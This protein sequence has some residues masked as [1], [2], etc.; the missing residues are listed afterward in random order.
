MANCVL[1]NNSGDWIGCPVRVFR[2]LFIY[3]QNA[4]SPRVVSMVA[5]LQLVGGGGVKWA[6]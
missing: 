1:V 5:W 3:L 4:T 2:G 6:R